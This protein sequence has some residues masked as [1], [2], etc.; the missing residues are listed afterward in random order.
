[1]S[2]ESFARR[3]PVTALLL[4]VLMVAAIASLGAIAPPGEW[5]AGLEKPS[6]N[7]PNW[8]FGPA[9]TVLYL[10]I[11]L[12]TWLLWR[13][14]AGPARTRALRLNAAQLVLNAAWTPVFFGLQQLGL[15]FAIIVVL[16]LLIAATIWAAWPVRR[17]AALLLLPYL[18]W[19][20]FASV[21]NGSIWWLN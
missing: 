14:P 19:V 12:A 3:H 20:G 13:A 5:Y 21:L 11:A 9:W 6:F 7:P 2:T 10:M 8:V 4:C 16:W 1:M 18:A 17:A 15:A